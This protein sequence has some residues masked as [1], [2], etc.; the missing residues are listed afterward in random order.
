MAKDKNVQD[1]DLEEVEQINAFLNEC[2]VN[3]P[4]Q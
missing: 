3:V 2:R 4:N 1:S